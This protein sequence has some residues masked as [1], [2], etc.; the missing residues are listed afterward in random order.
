MKR[1]KC[2]IELGVGDGE[3]CVEKE[4]KGGIHLPEARE[5]PVQ[6]KYPSSGCQKHELSPACTSVIFKHRP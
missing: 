1:A 2:Y 4:G 6:V 3:R 5:S